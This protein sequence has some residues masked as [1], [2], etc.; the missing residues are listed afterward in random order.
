MLALFARKL[1]A[2]L[3]V[4]GEIKKCI[5]HFMFNFP[6]AWLRGIWK[7]GGNFPDDPTRRMRFHV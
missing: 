6:G 1:F 3:I 2:I 7:I 4:V 5:F